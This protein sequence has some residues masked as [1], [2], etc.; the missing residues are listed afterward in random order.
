M[1]RPTRPGH[2]PSDEAL[3]QQVA[4][5]VSPLRRKRRIAHVDDPKSSPGEPP[6]PAPHLRRSPTPLVASPAQERTR[7]PE[8]PPPAPATNFDRRQKRRV[9]SG[10]DEITARLD[11][12]GM[13]EH[14]AHVRLT[15]FIRRSAVEGHR[16]VLVITGKGRD[17]IGEPA[18]RFE[19]GRRRGGSGVLRR[20]V[21]RWLSEPGIAPFVV[22][23]SEATPRHGGAGAL[24]VRLRRMTD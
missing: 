22:S 23:Y 12:H 1:K 15:Q 9:A 16:L 2:R 17:D 4:A 10:R 11:L 14:E 3:W 6:R 18:A 5:T 24:Y 21:P 19:L 20:N 8:P 13:R 7:L